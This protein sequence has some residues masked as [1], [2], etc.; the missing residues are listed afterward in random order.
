MSAP[1]ITP[2][3]LYVGTERMHPPP[4]VVVFFMFVFLSVRW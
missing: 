1:A 2:A 4:V 3:D